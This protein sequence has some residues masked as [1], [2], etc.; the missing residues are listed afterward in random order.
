MQERPKRLHPFW[1]LIKSDGGFMQERPKRLHPFFALIKSDGGCHS[2]ANRKSQ[3]SESD[4][5]GS[6]FARG[7]NH[8]RGR[9]YS[10]VVYIRKSL[11]FVGPNYSTVTPTTLVPSSSEVI[12]R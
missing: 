3:R 2:Q 8:P 7:A 5:W 1:N 4:L 6:L 10:E 9:L 11:I 12:V